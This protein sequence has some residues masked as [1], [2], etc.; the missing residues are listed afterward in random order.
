MLHDYVKN[1]ETIR[2]LIRNHI[3]KMGY[4]PKNT[5]LEMIAKRISLSYKSYF[6]AEIKS[7]VDAS[8][9]EESVIKRFFGWDICLPVEMFDF[10]SDDEEAI[11]K[12]IFWDTLHVNTYKA[13]ANSIA[14][15]A[16]SDFI[17]ELKGKT[18]SPF[19]C[20]AKTFKTV[21]DYV[22]K[23]YS[24][25]K[26]LIYLKWAY[27]NS[28]FEFGLNNGFGRRIL[29]SYDPVLGAKEKSQ[30]YMGDMLY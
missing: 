11:Q 24:Q 21:M 2:G 25:V 19:V 9:W 1:R 26:S 8:S 10:S 6:E 7:L 28:V 12:L 22:Q 5:D 15:C 29:I 4:T 16:F 14:L 27:P 30:T 3:I 20:G 13:G 17:R 23:N 18:F